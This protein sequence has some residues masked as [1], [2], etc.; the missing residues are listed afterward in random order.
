M[1]LYERDPARL[2]HVKH[3]T[4]VLPPVTIYQ[5]CVMTY[6][7]HHTRFKRLWNILK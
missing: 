1:E 3:D 2:N 6:R 5:I 7:S 4:T